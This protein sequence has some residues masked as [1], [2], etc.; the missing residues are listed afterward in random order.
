MEIKDC[1]NYLIERDGRVYNIRED[2]YM[3]HSNHSAGY[4]KVSLVDKDGQKKYPLIHRLIAL[5]YIPNPKN[6]P[7]VDHKNRRRKDNRLENL[8]WISPRDNQLNSKR[9]SNQEKYISETNSGKY[10]FCIKNN[11]NKY[12]KTWDT[13]AE[14]ICDKMIYIKMNDLKLN[15]YSSSSLSVSNSCNPEPNV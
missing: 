13:L 10:L 6:L 11:V 1:P 5:A 3:K 2:M 7:M 4:M 8:H 15:Y 12:R 14:A 9:Y